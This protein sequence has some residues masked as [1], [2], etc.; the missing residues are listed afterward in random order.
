[1]KISKEDI[2]KKKEYLK[3]LT[4]NIIK[5]NNKQK[6]LKRQLSINEKKENNYIEEKEEVF[7]WLKKNKES[8]I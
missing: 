6:A 2:M 4:K 5:L 8:Q 3:F 1:M 7:K